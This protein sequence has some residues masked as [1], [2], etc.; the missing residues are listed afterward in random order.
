[1][2]G[3]AGSDEA[4]MPVLNL[5]PMFLFLTCLIYVVVCL[6]TVAEFGPHMTLN[7]NCVADPLRAT[8]S[9]E[10]APPSN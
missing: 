9:S 7:L 2:I 3:Q 4:N 10:V 1:M 8:S 5:D 6:V